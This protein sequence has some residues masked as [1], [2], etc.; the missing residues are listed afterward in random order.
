MTRLVYFSIVLKITAYAPNDATFEQREQKTNK[1]NEG[2]S[3]KLMVFKIVT[4]F[5]LTQFLTLP[6]TFRTYDLNM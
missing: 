2:K 4:C 6:V 5:E 3:E 1:L